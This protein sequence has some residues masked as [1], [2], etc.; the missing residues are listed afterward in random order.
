MTTSHTHTRTEINPWSRLRSIGAAACLVGVP[1]SALGWFVSPQEFYSAWLTAFF[2]WLGI[3]LG[4]LGWITIQGMAGGR[5]GLLVRGIMECSSRTMPLMV[6]LFLPIWL[7][8][9][10]IYEWANAEYVQHHPVLLKKAGYLNVPGFQIR[11]V[12]YLTLW[13]VTAWIFSRMPL[14]YESAKHAELAS[15]WQRYS[16]MAFILYGFS[17]TLAAVDWM[18]SLEPEWFS[19]MYGLIHIAGQGVSGMAFAIV[20]LN[21]LRK[22]E[23]WADTIAP[24][25]TGD[26]GSLLQAAVMFWAYTSFFSIPGDL[27]RKSAGRERVVSAPKSERLAVPDSG[28]AGLRFHFAVRVAADST[29]ETK[30]ARYGT[31]C[32]LSADHALF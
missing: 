10:Q 2:F 29:K 22:A 25:P 1:L 14:R 11:A 28:V 13:S 17:M 24:E 32:E 7:N 20:I 16:G 23:P 4:S 6:V 9:G 21:M 12:V 26:L 8:A 31:D 18:M 27:V 15:N 30:S 5:W 19:T 3:S